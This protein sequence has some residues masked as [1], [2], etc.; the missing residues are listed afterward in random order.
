MDYSQFYIK[1]NVF[2]MKGLFLSLVLF[3]VF[4]S[5][6]A[7]GQNKGCLLVVN[8]YDNTV[9]ILDL[10]SN[11]EIISIQTGS[12][13]HEVAVSENGKMAAVTNYGTQAPGNSVTIIDV[14]NKK[15]V[16]EINLGEY[17][18]PHGIEFLN[19]SEI[20]VTCEKQGALIKV[21]IEDNKVDLLA[22][23]DQRIG[24]MVAISKKKKYA[25]VA[26]V[27]SGT[28]SKIDIKKAKFID[29]L[30][31]KKGIE[32][33][34]VSPDGKEVWV[35][36]RYTSLVS[37]ADAKTYDS[38]ATMKANKVA[39]RIKISPNGKYAVVSNGESANISIYNA[40]QKKHI[41]DISLFNL[42]TPTEQRPKDLPSVP[43]GI[44]FSNNSKHVFVACA[45]YNLVAVIDT[46]SW[47]LV[48]TI[49]TGNVPD[50]VY[51]SSINH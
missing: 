42:H 13:P 51:Y 18:R 10:N 23:T 20:I 34:E 12:G 11:K 21:N 15:K 1:E 47:E 49:K 29:Y 6:Q 31:F 24:H 16:K 5:N 45:N 19:N 37:V 35:S 3:L 44:A 39:F 2:R 50:G 38:I 7:I 46:N 8:K 9:S 4:V 27:L 43:V 33:I 30:N 14:V 32:G 22:K 17:Q 25:Y 26:N 36:N 48:N 41:K 40:K 28:V